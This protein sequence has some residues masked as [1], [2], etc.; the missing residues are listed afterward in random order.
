MNK[1]T[2][3]RAT[4]LKPLLPILLSV[5]LSAC[6]SSSNKSA[7]IETLSGK[8]VGVQVEGLSYKTPSFSGET[9]A[10]GSFTY[11]TGETVSF[12]V[13]DIAVGETKG[14]TEVTFFDLAGIANPAAVSQDARAKLQD[15]TTVHEH[16]KL[17]NLVVFFDAID[18]DG[19]YANGI[20]VPSQLNEL[21]LGKT[22]DIKGTSFQDFEK[23]FGDSQLLD[24]AV[25]AGVWTRAPETTPAMTALDMFY[26]NIGEPVQLSVVTETLTDSGND[27]TIN[28]KNTTTYDEFGNKSG[29]YKDY[30]ND[31]T[32]ESQEIWT[33][34]EAL[35]TLE[36]KA[37]K[38]GNDI[39]ES[40]DSTTTVLYDDSVTASD[41]Q[42]Y[43]YYNDET[44][45]LEYKSTQTLSYSA[46]GELSKSE[47]L[48]ESPNST[49]KSSSIYTRDAD[50]RLTKLEIDDG[51]DGSI[52][53]IETHLFNEVTKA[54]STEIDT[55]ADGVA[56]EISYATYDDNS[57]ILT[58]SEDSNADGVIDALETNTYDA[59]GNPVKMTSE[60]NGEVIKVI[61]REYNTA[62]NKL[63]EQ[64]TDS[65]DSDNNSLETY[66]Y[67]ADGNLKIHTIYSWLNGVKYLQYQTFHD[68]NGGRSLMKYD[69]YAEVTQTE[70]T[71]YD[72]QGNLLETSSFSYQDGVESS[73]LVKVYS[74]DSE[75]RLSK[76][77]E[78]ANGSL[79]DSKNYVYDSAGN[80]TSI[81][82]D[83]ISESGSVSTESY[84]YDN[85]ASWTTL[86]SSL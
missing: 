23:Q 52:D 83:A 60:V 9:S 73:S 48:Y 7:T 75:N 14:S 64:L 13:G 86:Y 35:T 58:Y 10:D 76:V 74:Y 70:S 47:N 77:T 20:T 38:N 22:L 41:T 12:F 46:D 19:N 56:D 78:T 81:V 42:V 51:S 32:P 50:G 66:Q 5:G 34:N 39:F 54:S 40:T 68:A 85:V 84:V 33:Y 63:S 80:L 25:A 26:K 21:A 3:S 57:N 18:E 4:K 1:K 59:N 61:D 30:D 24:D 71:S 69:E 67:G 11:K 36:H 44:G 27:G 8:I 45:T 28:K 43:A 6:N 2:I 65:T 53:R 79:V 17:S 31:G 82:N 15:N 37:D 62:G 16:D 55:N 49:G 29:E 72:D